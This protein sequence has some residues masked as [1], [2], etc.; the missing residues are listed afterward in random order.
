[1]ETIKQRI[2]QFKKWLD[3]INKFIRDVPKGILQVN[4]ANIKKMLEPYVSKCLDKMK[5]YVYNLVKKKSD[6]L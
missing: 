1:M 3:D 6:A 5:E 2:T 4:G